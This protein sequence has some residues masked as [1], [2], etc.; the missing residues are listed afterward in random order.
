VLWLSTASRAAADEPTL[1]WNPR[2]TR[3][4][5][6]QYMLTGVMA[7]G[8]LATDQLLHASSSPRW[9]GGI[10]LDGQASSLLGA[11]SERGRRSASEVSDYL[12]FGL[13]FY[14]FV[15]DSALVAAGIH[16]NYDVAF[17]MAM[18][19]AQGVLLTKLVTGLTKDL[20]GR[21][22]PD[23]EGCESGDELACGSSN[24]SFISGHTSGAFAGAGL[25][26]AH[27]QNLPL[28]G[29]NALGAVACGL[30]LGTA[31]AVGALRLVA[32]RHH[33]TDVLA[34][35]AVGL[36]AGYLLP[37][38]LNYDFGESK[39]ESDAVLMPIAGDG[40]LGVSYMRSW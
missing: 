40:T 28:Y 16:G 38:L 25:I 18:I 27:H 3:F 11:S 33:M 34:G 23:A 22:R 29:D 19:S 9:R 4:T 36:A 32:G 26:C 8:L 35:A 13:M 21:A 31:T 24:E 5:T 15:M 1:R 10:L 39:S 17:Q 37:N 6:T 30:S 20:V 12:A 7:G 14:P 2:F